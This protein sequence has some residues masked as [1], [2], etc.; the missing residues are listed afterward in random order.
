MKKSAVGIVLEAFVDFLVPQHTRSFLDI[1]NLQKQRLPYKIL[2]QDH[3][4]GN[5]G[6][7]PSGTFWVVNIESCD[8]TVDN[9]IG[10]FR[11]SAVDDVLVG[12]CKLG[13]WHLGSSSVIRRESVP[14]NDVRRR[15]VAYGGRPNNVRLWGQ[16]IGIAEYVG[17]KD[18][19]LGAVRRGGSWRLFPKLSFTF[20]LPRDTAARYVLEPGVRSRKSDGNAIG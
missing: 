18:L 12:F 3:H 20:Q 14:S 5:A 1:N 13:C 15:W 6:E 9:L 2:G 16:K 19:K 8:S 17:R 4:S 10:G 11:D 7:G